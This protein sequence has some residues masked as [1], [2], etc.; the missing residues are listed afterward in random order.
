[1]DTTVVG[2]GDRLARIA[3]TYESFEDAVRLDVKVR[4]SLS[5]KESPEDVYH[6]NYLPRDYYPKWEPIWGGHQRFSSFQANTT[7]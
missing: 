3:V 7:S 5:R 2:H 1:E 4:E 6:I